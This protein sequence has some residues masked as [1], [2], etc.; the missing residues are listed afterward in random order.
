MLVLKWGSPAFG[1]GT[2]NVC[3]RELTRENRQTFESLA[4]AAI[5]LLYL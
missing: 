4:G 1:A 3:L 5:A 2:V